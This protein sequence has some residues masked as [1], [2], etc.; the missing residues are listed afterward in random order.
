MTKFNSILASILGEKENVD[1]E[2]YFLTM[3]SFTASIFL[4]IL[5]I[6]HLIISLKIEP[7]YLASG[8][9]I[10]LLGLYFIFRFSKYLFA[11]KLFLTIFGLVFLDLTWH[12]K[13]L[14]LGPVLF[15]IFA[16][17]ALVIWVWNGKSL[18]IMLT[19]YFIN[20]A[21]LFT[22][23]YT[24]PDFVLIYPNMKIRSIDIYLNFFCYASLMI[25]ILSRIK[26][27]FLKQKEK[28]VNSDKLKSAF[29][30]NMSHEIRTPMNAIV[31]FGELLNDETDSAKRSEYL[32]IIQNSSN[33]LLRLIDEIIDL[34]KIEAGDIQVRYSNFS[35]KEMFIELKNIYSIEI[36]KR[37][38]SDIQ[39]SYDL[40]DGDYII[41]SDQLCVQ[42]VLSNLLN[43]AIKFTS[44]GTITFSCKKTDN[45]LVFSVSDTGTGIPEDDQKKIFERFIKFDYQGMN[46]E[47]T[48][49]GLSIVEKLIGMLNGRIWLTSVVGVGTNFFFSLPFTNRA[50]LSAPDK[51]VQK[52]PTSNNI[53]S[54]KVVL[55]VEDDKNSIILIKEI[56]KQLNIEIHHVCN[57]E[58]A[59]E[60]VKN[61]PVTHLILMDIKLPFMDGYKATTAINKINPNI[62]IIAQTA[63][64]MLGDKEKAISAGCDDYVTKPLDAKELQELVKMHLSN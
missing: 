34:S 47:G 36:I 40:P 42:Q 32:N 37:E 60:F 17:G 3:T 6:S 25:F 29:L 4:V 9:S 56:L 46:I 62:V 44:Q 31:G 43:N 49:I 54:N 5:S 33:S 7:I 30:A 18:V 21:I 2:R 26:T 51:N 1:S 12:S 14:S 61:N 20:I 50:T 11:P 28:A 16:F 59:I 22:I 64:A 53:E 8:S 10:V 19:I 63:Y 35:I 52:T 55:V 15:F 58:I 23:E 57:G 24:T 38:K 45:K 48:G 39:L 41:R 13:F 27:D